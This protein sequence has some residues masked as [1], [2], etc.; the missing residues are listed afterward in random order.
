MNTPVSIIIPV[1]NKWELTRACLESIAEHARGYP[2]EVVVVDNASSD[3]TPLEAPA[4]GHALFGDTFV[5]LRQSE[6]RNFSGA[7][8]IG[9]MAARSDLLLFLNNDTVVTPGWLPPLVDTLLT[10]DKK[11][12]AVGPL[13]LYPEFGG[14]KDRV[15]HAGI[16][17]SPAMHLLHLY[18]G[19]PADHPAVNYLRVV[20]A[21]TAAAFLV[22][23]SL[24]QEY[25]GFYEGFVNGFE[26]VDLCARLW[27]KNYVFLV[28]PE[29]RVYHLQG[30]TPGRHAHETENAD[31][32]ASRSFHL[33]GPDYHL[34]LA[35]DGYELA[36]S[37][38]LAFHPE[39]PDPKRELFKTRFLRDGNELMV[40]SL[41]DAEPFWNDGYAWLAERWER[42]GRLEE[43]FFC[44][45]QA[46][47]I[48]VDP[49]T[50]VPLFS[51]A[52]RLGIE[53]VQY[54]RSGLEK[55]P[56]RFGYFMKTAQDLRQHY[57]AYGLDVVVRQCDAWLARSGGFRARVLRP[58]VVA[59][60]K[61]G[62]DVRRLVNMSD[63]S[64]L[65]AAGGEDSAP[66]VAAQAGEG[67]ATA[68][69][70]GRGPV[71]VSEN[72]NARLP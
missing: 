40:D 42:Q 44:R 27:E 1:H 34:H 67:T 8:N 23:K 63:P 5:Y 55:F 16:T 2:L 62:V 58:A 25:Q 9:A 3:A 60:M 46:A 32:I 38:W 30:Q 59:L 39:L 21:I 43:A 7:C 52:R 4:L 53:D 31:L 18:E 28:Q 61:E 64:S 20:Q 6:N 70:G 10:T 51:L 14:K 45:V 41:L 15:Q 26:D 37:R 19:I 24:F 36:L 57:A 49:D 71:L 54:V 35:R 29:S 56:L 33:L 12:G 66:G 69:S 47:R 22:R 50:L 11:V 17:I 13:L 65:D 72:C 68:G 48:K